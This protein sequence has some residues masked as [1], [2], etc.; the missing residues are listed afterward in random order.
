MG[1]DPIF[2]EGD[3]QEVVRALQS[4][5]GSLCPFGNIIADTHSVLVDF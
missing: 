4:E 5:E 3:A 1:F 2:L